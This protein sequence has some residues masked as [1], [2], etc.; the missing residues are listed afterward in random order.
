[1]RESEYTNPELQD[2]EVKIETLKEYAIFLRPEYDIY[3]NA[4]AKVVDKAEDTTK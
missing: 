2:E 4:F 1:M 3:I